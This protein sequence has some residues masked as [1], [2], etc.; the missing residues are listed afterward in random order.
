MEKT[1]VILLLLGSLSWALGGDALPTQP[2]SD[3]HTVLQDHNTKLAEMIQQLQ[4][5]TQVRQVAFSAS[6]GVSSKVTLGP[7]S[8]HTPLNYTYVMSN[9]GNAYSPTTGVFT[10]PVKGAYHFDFF[11]AGSGHTAVML[12]KNDEHTFAASKHAQEFSTTGNGVTLLLEVGD[13]VSLLLWQQCT[14][15]DNQNHH[16]T[17]SGR[18]LFAL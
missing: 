3:L 5:L 13:R 2:L 14:I 7:F 1:Q 16:S 12:V 18:L 4:T 15:F 17:F 8:G 10:A 9:V 6:L 11:A